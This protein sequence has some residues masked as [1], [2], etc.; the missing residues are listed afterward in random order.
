MDYLLKPFDRERFARSMAKA[1][2]LIRMEHLSDYQAQLATA[3]AGLG[4]AR[5]YPDRLLVRSGESHQL[6][7]AADILHISAEGNYIRLHTL[8]ANYQMRER[9]VGIIER[10]DPAVFCRIH[11]SH[12]VNLD[13]I[14]K[15]LPWFGG[16]YLVMMDDGSRLTLSRNYRDALKGFM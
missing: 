5:K 9:M 10:L 8:G 3:L 4:S 15:I 16:D 12:I 6:I 13:H 1:R 11:R 7:K 14:H 2:T